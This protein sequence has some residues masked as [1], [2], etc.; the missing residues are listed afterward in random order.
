MMLE[1]GNLGVQPLVPLGQSLPHELGSGDWGAEHARVQ[2][3]RRANQPPRRQRS[4]L[5]T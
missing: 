2:L 4:E 1:H 5:L 3:R